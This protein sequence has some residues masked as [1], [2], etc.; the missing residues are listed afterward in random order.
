MLCSESF[1]VSAYNELSNYI[2]SISDLKMYLWLFCLY[3]QFEN[4]IPCVG[5]LYTLLYM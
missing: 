3:E 4:C 5:N 1:K 2:L